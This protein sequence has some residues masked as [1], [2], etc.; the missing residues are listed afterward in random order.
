ML[1]SEVEKLARKGRQISVPDMSA[2]T[3]RPRTA[4][5]RAIHRKE[6]RAVWLGRTPMI[7][8]GEALRLLGI[9][10]APEPIAA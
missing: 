1:A 5:Y 9:E 8:P 2:A 6:L 10:S 4:F 3:G 7:L